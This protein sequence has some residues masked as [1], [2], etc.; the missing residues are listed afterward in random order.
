MK[1]NLRNHQEFE[2]YRLDILMGGKN[3]LGGEPTHYPCIVVRDCEHAV[4]IYLEDF[5]Q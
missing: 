1:K 3:Y 4:Y 5:N 2:N